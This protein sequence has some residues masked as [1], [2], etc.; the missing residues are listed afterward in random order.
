MSM[1][2]LRTLIGGIRKKTYA[3]IVLNNNGTGYKII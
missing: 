2:A 3:N 1:D